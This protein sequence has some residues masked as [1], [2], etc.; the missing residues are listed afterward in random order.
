MAYMIGLLVDEYG[1]LTDG[2]DVF[3]VDTIDHDWETPYPRY[4]G[5][6]EFTWQAGELGE[7][8]GVF[9]HPEIRDWVC[10]EQ[11]WSVLQRTSPGDLHLIGEG[12]LDGRRLLVVQVV[13]MLDIVDREAS[14]IDR[15]ETYEILQ[16]PTFVGQSR[17][18]VAGRAF[19]VPGSYTDVFVGQAVKEA[20]EAANVT[21]LSYTP[22]E[23][24]P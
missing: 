10:D 15:Y 11:A 5:V 6:A 4:D 17:N 7:Q 14:I 1:Y 23:F 2:E 9:R 13:A 16:F 8:P 24:S 22:V 3:P 12:R 20:L 21:G 18:A 19:R